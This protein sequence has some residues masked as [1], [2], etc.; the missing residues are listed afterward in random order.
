MK[1][2]EDYAKAVSLL[3]SLTSRQNM[4]SITMELNYVISQRQAKQKMYKV[5]GKLKQL[6][7]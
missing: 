1:I 6:E 4:M 5:G 7:S 3:A 2:M